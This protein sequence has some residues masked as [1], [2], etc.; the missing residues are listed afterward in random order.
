MATRFI[1]VFATALVLIAIFQLFFRYQ[2]IEQYLKLGESSGTR[3]TRIDRLTG[4][5]CVM[6]CTY[7]PAR[8]TPAPAT[9]NPEP[10]ATPQMQ[11]QADAKIIDYLRHTVVIPLAAEQRT[12]YRWRIMGHYTPSGQEESGRAVVGTP[13]P[14]ANIYSHWES[15]ITPEGKFYVRLVCYCDSTG[16]GWYY[17]YDPRINEKME[18]I[19]NEVLERKYHLAW[20]SREKNGVSP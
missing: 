4:A 15:A 5:S 20:Q 16:S 19:G 13:E 14:D 3:I 17:E 8:T 1:A 18:V 9:T 10:T 12:R 2:Y 6:P 7:A 11:D